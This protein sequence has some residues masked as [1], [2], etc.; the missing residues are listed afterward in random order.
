MNENGFVNIPD[1]SLLL[2]ERGLKSAGTGIKSPSDPVAPLA[3]ARI[4]IPGGSSDNLSV[5]VA[6]LAGAR[7]EIRYA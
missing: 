3:G 4:E 5:C 6:P 7:I 2:R 1:G